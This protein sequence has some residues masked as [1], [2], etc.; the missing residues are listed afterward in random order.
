MLMSL[1]LLLPS[2]HAEASGPHDL[3]TIHTT[4]FQSEEALSL[5]L[6]EGAHLRAGS[7]T[8]VATSDGRKG[9]RA[10]TVGGI[11]VDI[12]PDTVKLQLPLE[13]PPGHYEIR[14]LDLELDWVHAPLELRDCRPILDLRS[15]TLLH[16]VQGTLELGSCRSTRA[17]LSARAW[18]E[19]EVFLDP[20]VE[21][22]GS[23]GRLLTVE[24]VAAVPGRFTVRGSS[25]SAIGWIGQHPLDPGQYRLLVDSPLVDLTWREDTGTTESGSLDR[26]GPV[27]S[28]LPRLS[29]AYALGGPAVIGLTAAWVGALRRRRER[30]RAAPS[31]L[32]ETAAHRRSEGARRL[33]EWTL[34]VVCLF[35]ILLDVVP[36]ERWGVVVGTLAI[37]SVTATFVVQAAGGALFRGRGHWGVALLALALALGAPHVLAWSI[38][39]FGSSLLYLITAGLLLAQLLGKHTEGRPS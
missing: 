31:K 22:G 29:L 39:P 27:V 3:G 17:D 12:G 37:V 14:D 15:A 4:V 6:P 8:V 20:L 7:F 25:P 1:G 33:S 26:D 36:P 2:L 38:S 5:A 16:P 35:L 13:S 9:S 18:S 23:S 21:D 32:E 19:L 10:T 30:E 28:A 11:R 24:P 34:V